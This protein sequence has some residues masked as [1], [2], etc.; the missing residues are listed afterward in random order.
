LIQK[1]ITMSRIGKKPVSVVDGV[2]VSVDGQRI[3]VEGPKG[4]LEYV[5]RPEVSVEYDADDKR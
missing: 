5:C 4:K 1:E 2:A 3:T